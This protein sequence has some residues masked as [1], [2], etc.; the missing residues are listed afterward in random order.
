MPHPRTMFRD[1]VMVVESGHTYERSA[2]LA[3]FGATGPRTRSRASR[4]SGS[5]K[6]MTI[7]AMR[8]RFRIGWTSIGRDT[9][10]T[11][12]SQKLPEPAKDDGTRS[13]DDRGDVGVLRTWRAMCPDC[14]RGGRRLRD[15]STGKG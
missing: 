2:V 1:P 14:R 12:Q 10:Q 15:R 9:G 8:N 3:H 13:C 11:G 4:L 5:T 6:V 7:W